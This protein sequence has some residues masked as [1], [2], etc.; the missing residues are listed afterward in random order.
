MGRRR[1]N[2]SHPNMKRRPR[3]HPDRL[4]WVDLGMCAAKAQFTLNREGQARRS[5]VG[6]IAV[7][8]RT[9]KKGQEAGIEVMLT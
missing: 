5:L 9:T 3:H 4:L 7:V 8:A 2:G 6:R 1:L